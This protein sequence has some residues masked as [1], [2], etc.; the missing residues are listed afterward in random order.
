M[1]LEKIKQITED[2]NKLI[3]LIEYKLSIIQQYDD[4][5]KIT[6]HNY[7]NIE[8]YDDHVTII[9][10]DYRLDFDPYELNIPI[11]WILLD[12]LELKDIVITYRDLRIERDRVESERKRF[13]ALARE[14]ARERELYE[15]LKQKFNE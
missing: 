10:N 9:V 13:E 14:Q 3:Q 1:N 5:F 12:D 15:K 11:D 4:F 8:L 2:Y 6:S 7:I